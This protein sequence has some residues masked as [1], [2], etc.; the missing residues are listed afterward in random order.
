MSLE[1]KAEAA[2]EESFKCGCR[3]CPECFAPLIVMAR[4][5]ARDALEQIYRVAPSSDREAQIDAALKAAEGK[6]Q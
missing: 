2:L 1:E 6:Q 3:H 5:F 4:D